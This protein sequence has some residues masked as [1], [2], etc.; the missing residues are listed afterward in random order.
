MKTKIL[1]VTTFLFFSLFFVSFFSSC[2]KDNAEIDDVITSTNGIHKMKVI[3]KGDSWLVTTMT[4]VG[5]TDNGDLSLLCDENKK[6][7]DGLLFE[8]TGSFEFEVQTAIEVSNLLCSATM[9][10]IEKASCTITIEGY[11]NDKLVKSDAKSY[12]LENSGETMLL[13]TDGIK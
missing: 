5:K 12:S 3:V 7:Y 13:A 2:S 10:S 8:R 4:F 6:V 11:I 9:V 1:S